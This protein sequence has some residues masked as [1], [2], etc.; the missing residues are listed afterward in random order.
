[1]R[2]FKALVTVGNY[3]EKINY[4]VN[5]TVDEKNKSLFYLENDAKKTFVLY[6]YTS[7]ILKRDNEEIYM[8][9]NFIENQTTVNNLFLKKV[10]NSLDLE[11]FTNKILKDNN[12]IQI[13]YE[14]NHEKYIF[15]IEKQEGE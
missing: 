11:I 13:E 2:N 1:M 12:K 10:N 5:I 3:N 8:V 9:L 6:E 4:K 15:K 7:N 14:L